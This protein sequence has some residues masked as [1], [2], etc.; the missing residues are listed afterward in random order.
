MKKM[1][2]FATLILA[3]HN[4]ITRDNVEA[5]IEEI[6]EMYG[7]YIKCQKFSCDKIDNSWRK[8]DETTEIPNIKT[9]K[10]L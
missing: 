7:K 1:L 2:Y 6:W 5:K 9:I 4:P 8:F 3:I 10:I